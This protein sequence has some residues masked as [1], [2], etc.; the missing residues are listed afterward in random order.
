[1]HQSTFAV[2]QVS[3]GNWVVDATSKSDARVTRLVGVYVSETAAARWITDHPA[4]WF[5]A[6]VS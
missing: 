4:E 5:E 3:T 1:M 2:R 6:R